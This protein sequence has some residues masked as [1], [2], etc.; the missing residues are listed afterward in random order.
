MMG[1]TLITHQTGPEGR[2]VHRL[3]RGSVRNFK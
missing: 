2:K 1:K 3:Y